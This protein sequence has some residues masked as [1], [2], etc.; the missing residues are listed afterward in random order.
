MTPEQYE[1]RVLGM[2]RYVERLAF[3]CPDSCRGWWHHARETVRHLT[4][5]IDADYYDLPRPTYPDTGIPHLN[6]DIARHRDWFDQRWRR[7]GKE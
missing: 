4:E 1:A 5:V 2:E 6:E 3:L 7:D